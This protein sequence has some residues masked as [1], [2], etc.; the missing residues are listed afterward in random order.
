MI[1]RGRCI[2]SAPIPPH[3]Y[4]WRYSGRLAMSSAGDSS[5][6]G[7]RGV[8]LGTNRLEA[9]VDGVFAVVMTLLVLDITVPSPAAPLAAAHLL[10]NLVA[11]QTPLLSYALSLVIAGVYWVGHHNQFAYI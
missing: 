5:G 9:L 1:P 6:H 4:G 7:G 2:S 11:L 3:S 8:G 10:K